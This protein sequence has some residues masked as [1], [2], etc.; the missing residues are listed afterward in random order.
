MQSSTSA[1]DT[2]SLPSLECGLKIT[3][4]LLKTTKCFKIAASFIPGSCIL[5]LPRS[6]G[7]L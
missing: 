3:T 7:D 4:K 5:S 2:L 6:G 1:Y